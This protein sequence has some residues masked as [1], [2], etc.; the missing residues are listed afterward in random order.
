MEKTIQGAKP[1]IAQELRE[2]FSREGILTQLEEAVTGRGGGRSSTI[3]E[4]WDLEPKV[5]FAKARE[6][7]HQAQRGLET[8]GSDMMWW[9]Y[10]SDETIARCLIAFFYR[11]DKGVAE[12][13]KLPDTEGRVLMDKLAELT[14]W[15]VQLISDH[16]HKWGECGH[17]AHSEGSNKACKKGKI[18][19]GGLV[20][21][22]CEQ[23]GKDH[24]DGNPIDFLTLGKGQVAEP[25]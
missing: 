11:L 25:S 16:Q 15:A 18:N 5:G 12:F 23:C 7:L 20:H 19:Y 17:E 6:Y 14:V 13:P 21:T 9:S 8:A 4:Y 3:R 1:K 22:I 24:Y 2:S 10:S